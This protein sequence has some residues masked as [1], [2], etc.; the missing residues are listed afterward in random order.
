MIFLYPWILVSLVIFNRLFKSIKSKNKSGP[1]D[2]GE[3]FFLIV[4][5]YGFVPSIGFMLVEMGIGQIIDSRLLV[6]G[7]LKG[8]VEYVQY[9]HMAFIVTFIVV[10][11]L[12]HIPKVNIVYEHS[13]QARPLVAPFVIIAL[14]LSVILPILTRLFGADVGSDYIS[15][16]TAL[17]SAPLIVQQFFGVANQIHFA[18]MIA[19]VV[20]TVAAY[21]GKH[22]FVASGLCFYLVFVSISGGSRTSAFLSFFAYIVSASTYVANFDIKKITLFVLPALVLFMISGALRD[23]NQEYDYLSLFQTGEFT[24]VF[25]TA[26]DLHELLKSGGDISLYFY[27]AD[28]LRL[29]PSQLLGISKVDP[30][31][32]YVS[33]Y[34]EYYHDAGGGFAFGLMAECAIGFGVYDAIARGFILAIIFAVISNKLIT[35]TSNVKNVFVYIWLIVVSYLSYRDTTF[36]LGVRAL[37]QLVPVLILMRCFYFLNRVK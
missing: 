33:T 9:M 10:Y 27:I 18:S 35:S 36:S 16:Y 31:Q 15:S 21:P 32:W 11:N 7:Y 2:L 8:Q 14:S 28:F 5:L 22:F 26:M 20:L 3:A 24:A 1:L 6:R 30:A 37:Y 13:G 4:I 19:A 25:I 17:R 34:Y 12:L 29:I 23:D